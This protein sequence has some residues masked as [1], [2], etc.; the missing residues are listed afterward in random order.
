MLI[1]VCMYNSIHPRGDVKQTFLT[2]S[3]QLSRSYILIISRVVIDGQESETVFN[4][5]APQVDELY[6]LTNHYVTGTSFI[7][8]SITY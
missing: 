1:N 5:H 8:N 4:G 6:T 3:T 2:V 7:V